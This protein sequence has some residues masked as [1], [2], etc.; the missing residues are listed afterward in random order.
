MNLGSRSVGIYVR[1][2]SRP[3]NA[4]FLGKSK[5]RANVVSLGKTFYILNVVMVVSRRTTT[6]IDIAIAAIEVR[7]MITNHARACMLETRAIFAF[8]GLHSRT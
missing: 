3:R 6:I 4:H 7:E 1:G 8:V 2:S 5:R